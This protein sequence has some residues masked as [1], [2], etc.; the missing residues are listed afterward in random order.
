[1]KENHKETRAEAMH[2]LIAEGRWD[3]AT[4]YRHQVREQLR[5]RGTTKRQARDV[6]WKMMLEQFPPLGSGR[7]PARSADRTRM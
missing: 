3:Q 4:E 2:R 6:A 7:E 1:M 5:A